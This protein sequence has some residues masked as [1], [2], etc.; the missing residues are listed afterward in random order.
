VSAALNR[1]G[2]LVTVGLVVALLSGCAPATRE[3]SPD[4]ANAFQQSVSAITASAAADDI[5]AALAQ[6]QALERELMQQ[7]AAG[8]VSAARSAQILAAIELVRTDLLAAA[9]PET[10]TSTPTPEPDPG[11]DPGNKGRGKGNDK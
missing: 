7:S 3:I 8:N 5:D 1:G 11:T 9:P 10:P 2:A 4:T 6:L